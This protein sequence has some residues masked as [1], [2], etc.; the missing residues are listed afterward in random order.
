MA[1]ETPPQ[2]V[3]MDK[4][5]ESVKHVVNARIDRIEAEAKP[6]FSAQIDE[7]ERRVA[8]VVERMNAVE[9]EFKSKFD[10]EGAKAQQRLGAVVT[11]A[12]ERLEKSVTKGLVATVVIVLTVALGTFTTAY[13]QAEAELHKEVQ[14]FQS[15]MTDFQKDLTGAYKDIRDARVSVQTAVTDL[16]TQRRALQAATKAAEAE[17][18]RLKAMPRLPK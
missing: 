4:L 17:V 7:S 9:S 14:Q 6:R 18:A 2:D 5:V 15:Q 13:Y 16:E 12:Q 8:S 3:D 11:S 10:A 1:S